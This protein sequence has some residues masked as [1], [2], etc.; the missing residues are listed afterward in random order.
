[1]N[2]IGLENFPSTYL[3]FGFLARIALAMTLAITD[4]G[5]II[6]QGPL[7]AALC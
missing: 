5:D 7:S 3:V 2:T 4:G 6:E 1:M